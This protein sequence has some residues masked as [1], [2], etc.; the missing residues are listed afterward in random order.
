MQAISLPQKNRAYNAPMPHPEAH[1]FGQRMA[2]LRHEHGLSQA[3]LGRRLGISRGM[4][5]YYESCAKNPTVDFVEKVAALFDVPAA[6]LLGGTNGGAP[7]KKPGPA[8]RLAQLTEELSKL[9]KSK[10]RVVVEMLEGFLNQASK[11]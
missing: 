8:S 10:Q 5:A 3:E 6:D 7:K 4:V 2:A 1:P 9:P 11:S